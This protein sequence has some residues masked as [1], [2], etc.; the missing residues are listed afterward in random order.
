[1]ASNPARLRWLIRLDDDDDEDVGA[2]SNTN[3][4]TTDDDLLAALRSL[5]SWP[6]E[7]EEEKEKGS[8]N[9][10]GERSRG[11]SRLLL[12][13]GIHARPLDRRRALASCLAQHVA[14]CVGLGIAWEDIPGISRTVKGG[15]PFV[16]KG[17]RENGG[18]KGKD[19]AHATA[20]ASAAPNF[21]F[22]VSHDGPWLALAAEPLLLVGIDVTSPR[23]IGGGGWSRAEGG[24][25]GGKGKGSGS[26]ST[27]PALGVA[28][29]QRSLGSALAD[30]EWARV[31]LEPDAASQD[32]LFRKFWA[33]R[34]AWSKARGDGLGAG[35]LAR[36]EFSLGG[37]HGGDDEVD[38]VIDA[39]SEG[40]GE[41]AGEGDSRITL[42]LE[43]TPQKH[44]SFE[45][46][47]LPDGSALAVA[48]GPP[49]AVVDAGGTFS[50]TLG[51]ASMSAAEVEEAQRECR[52]S[53]R[54]L[55][56]SPRV[57]AKD[58]DGCYWHRLSVRALMEEAEMRKRG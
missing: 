23:V 9:S 20:N 48:M 51:R 33:L 57:A 5:P 4:N 50:R 19:G 13:R 21:N 10:I 58:S 8:V 34:E 31:A 17:A 55:T 43:G 44:W 38:D 52:R 45:L 7:D 12:H 54:A 32:A 18:V 15:K 16:R 47:D 28:R 37:S 35:D 41:E 53:R 36:A 30:S 40:N 6:A 2:G 29:L 1:M 3:S 26:N 24:S 49:S 56:S 22:N 27:P 46:R 42:K 14:V 39:N 25:G 11:L